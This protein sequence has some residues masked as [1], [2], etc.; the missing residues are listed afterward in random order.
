MRG[1]DIDTYIKLMEKLVDAGEKYLI[2]KKELENYED[3]FTNNDFENWL[4]NDKKKCE[5]LAKLQEKALEIEE[6]L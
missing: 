1:Y 4:E 3:S 5:I 2:A 6:R